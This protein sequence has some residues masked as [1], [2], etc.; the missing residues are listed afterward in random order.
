M[1]N[2][3]LG[4]VLLLFKGDYIA[5]TTYTQLD[6]VYYNGSSYVA[7]TT[8]RGN[9][10]DNTQYWQIMAL[11]GELSPTLSPEQ[12]ASIISQ[13]EEQA[14]FVRDNNYNHT[15]N[16]YTDQD[17]QALENIGNGTLTIQRNSTTLGTF[18]A[19]QQNNNT[20]NINVPTGIHELAGSDLLRQKITYDEINNHFFQA[21]PLKSGVFFYATQQLDTID[22]IDL[23]YTNKRDG[24]GMEA[25]YIEFESGAAGTTINI[26]PHVKQKTTNAD[27]SQ[28]NLW[29]RMKFYNDLLEIDEII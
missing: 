25:T 7:K 19:N 20:I 15:D 3:N 22:I 17:R 11:K 10:P 8:T 24:A 29:F 23:E 28:P 2:F 9:A 16:N 5:T 14:G 6:V 26:P 13:I 18:D 4:R 1:A 12:T 21:N 27:I